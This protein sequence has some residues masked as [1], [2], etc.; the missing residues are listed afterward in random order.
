MFTFEPKEKV[1]DVEENIIVDGKVVGSI[2]PYSSENSKDKFQASFSLPLYMLAIGYGTTRE[3]AIAN[4]L[5]NGN[6]GVAKAYCKI[7]ELSLAL[8]AR[9]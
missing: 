8:E 7:T 9:A 4:A 6:K 1:V 2:R 5:D 3:E